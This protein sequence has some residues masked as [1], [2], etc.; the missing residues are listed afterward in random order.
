MKRATSLSTPLVGLA[1]PFG[2][3]K[4]LG[5]R[6]KNMFVLQVHST[7]RALTRADLVGP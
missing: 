7:K 3:G 6:V 1:L 4:L 5:T 2:G